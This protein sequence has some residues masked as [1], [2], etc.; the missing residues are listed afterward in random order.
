MS[1]PEPLSGTLD[2]SSYLGVCPLQ[3]LH[4]MS[5]LRID[6]YSYPYQVDGTPSEFSI[7]VQKFPA[8]VQMVQRLSGSPLD[9]P[10]E[11]T[12]SKVLQTLFGP[13]WTLSEIKGTILG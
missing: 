6:T 5:L 1:T 12:A 7:L 11:L 4:Y 10:P 2:H 13:Y 9:A 8:L 3:Y